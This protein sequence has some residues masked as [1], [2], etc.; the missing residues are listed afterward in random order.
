MHYR[1]PLI[2]G[3]RYDRKY[4]LQVKLNILNNVFIVIFSILNNCHHHHHHDHN[5]HI[6]VEIIVS[7]QWN[8]ILVLDLFWDPKKDYKCEKHSEKRTSPFLLEKN[9][10]IGWNKAKL[11]MGKNI[12]SKL[13][14]LHDIQVFSP[15]GRVLPKLQSSILGEAEGGGGEEFLHLLI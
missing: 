4:A 3:N 13:W 9:M 1:E 14:I 15:F 8:K 12:Q 7:P 2:W 11:R 10:T 6:L 5:H